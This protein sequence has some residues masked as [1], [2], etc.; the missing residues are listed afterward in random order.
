MPGAGAFKLGAAQD[1]RGQI[2]MAFP[3]RTGLALTVCSQGITNFRRFL[4]SK[5]AG[6][7]H[8]VPMRG[9]TAFFTPTPIRLWYGWSGSHGA[10]EGAVQMCFR[11]QSQADGVSVN[12]TSQECPTAAPVTP[13][14]HAE[15]HQPTATPRCTQSGKSRVVKM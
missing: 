3:L 10:S 13:S 11:L 5:S 2:Q 6:V 12:S 14:D 15:R 7:G 1:G 4:R 8:W 9:A